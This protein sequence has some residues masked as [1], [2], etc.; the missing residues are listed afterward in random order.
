MGMT[1]SGTWVAALVL[2]AVFLLGLPAF[3]AGVEVYDIDLPTGNLWRYILLLLNLDEVVETV[4][5]TMFLL[6][7]LIILLGGTIAT[8]QYVW[9]A[10][11]CLAAFG[12]I[13]VAFNDQNLSGVY[14][15]GIEL[16]PRGLLVLGYVMASANFGVAGAAIPKEHRL[17]PVRYVFFA[18]AGLVWVLWYMS[19]ARSQS[20]AQIL[21]NGVG[22]CAGLSHMVALLTANRLDGTPD[23]ALRAGT[24]VFA[25]ILIIGAIIVSLGESDPQIDIIFYSRVVVLAVIVGLV[26]F[27]IRHI[28]AIRLDRELVIAKSI[29]DAKREAQVNKELLD[30]Q[31][32]YA[33]TQ[34]LARAQRLRFASASHD[35]RQ[36]IVSLR[37]S[38][39]A[40]THNQPDEVKDQ[41][42]TAFDYLDQLA[43][44]YV[45]E[46]DADFADDRYA[47][48]TE[49]SEEELVS[50]AILAD[51]LERMFRDEAEAKGLTFCVAAQDVEVR[52]KPLELMRIL[53]NLLSNAIKHTETG[54]AGLSVHT[55][56]T[57]A[58]FRIT[59]SGTMPDGDVFKAGQKGEASGGHGLG[60][61]IVEQLAR[62]NGM[63]L[64]YS[65][66]A[67]LGT[68]FRLD[69]PK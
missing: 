67:A 24:F 53:S 23:R 61:A 64:S 32:R 7:F 10:Y 51:T 47:S 50:T 17:A 63:A 37:S 13:W 68:V 45:T 12:L 65:S 1:R 41:L 6:A 36:P 44:S 29:E 54:E 66:D 35:L 34:E 26:G 57:G 14:W 20:E 16:R 18:M 4:A 15:S 38:M 2:G 28:L 9:G 46:T 58:I 19:L 11:T 31:L 3:P 69:V 49:T 60:L 56:P 52:A 8:R 43:E 33:E 48:G 62:K 5:F 22:L 42:R 55:S 21:F 25:A 40:L 59:N 30:T 39:S 27:F